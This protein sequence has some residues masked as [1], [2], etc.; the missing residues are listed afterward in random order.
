MERKEEEEN[1]VAISLQGPPRK[2]DYRRG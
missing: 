2:A 1:W